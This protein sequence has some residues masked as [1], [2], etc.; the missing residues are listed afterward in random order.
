MAIKFSIIIPVFREAAIINRTIDILKS[1]SVHDD[2]EIIAVDGRA[3][4]DTVKEIK[5]E[6][7]I[8]IISRKGAASSLIAE[9]QNLRAMS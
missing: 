2:L 5:H 7:V 9:P 6:G 3:D 4:G 1:L 8:K